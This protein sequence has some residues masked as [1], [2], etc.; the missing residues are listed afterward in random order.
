MNIREIKIQVDSI[1]AKVQRICETTFGLCKVQEVNFV[2]KDKIE[3]IVFVASLGVTYTFDIP[4]EVLEEK[5]FEKAVTKFQT[6]SNIQRA[7]TMNGILKLEKDETL[8][9]AVLKN[10]EGVISHFPVTA[11]NFL[12]IKSVNVD[13]NRN[14]TVEFIG[15]VNMIIGET[16]TS[17]GKV[18]VVQSVS[19][20]KGKLF[21]ACK[22]SEV[23]FSIK[24]ESVH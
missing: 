3:V 18:A 5:N 2:G 19:T 1:E 9:I 20:I 11:S 15:G 8:Q 17:D 13:I 14:V 10:G 21:H 4:S 24:V 7:I 16:L 12:G 22:G 6:T 23:V